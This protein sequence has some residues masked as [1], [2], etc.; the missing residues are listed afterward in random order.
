MKQT[1][2]WSYFPFLLGK[3]WWDIWSVVRRGE[4]ESIQYNRHSNPLTL[5]ARTFRLINYFHIFATNTFSNLD[6]YILWFR[7]SNPMTLAA[8][9]FC[10]ISYFHIFATNTFSNLDKYWGYGG[11]A[12]GKAILDQNKRKTNKIFRFWRIHFTLWKKFRG[13]ACVEAIMDQNR[14]TN[15][16]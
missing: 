13:A 9:T 2:I 1:L 11:A 5:A 7:K 15:K 14:K 16:N 3:F 6:K 8:R 10:L 12:C 4:R